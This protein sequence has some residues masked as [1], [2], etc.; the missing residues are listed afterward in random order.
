MQKRVALLQAQSA[1]ECVSNT[2]YFAKTSHQLSLLLH[3][4]FPHHPHLA[5]SDMSLKALAARYLSFLCSSPDLGSWEHLDM[6]LI[7]L[8]GV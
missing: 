7:G 2:M 8:T 6:A 5:N 3:V 4:L 1:L